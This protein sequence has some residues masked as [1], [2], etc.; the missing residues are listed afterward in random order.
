MHNFIKQLMIKIL[1]SILTSVLIITGSFLA[2][3]QK[4]TVTVINATNNNGKVSFALFDENG[5]P[6]EDYG[7]SNNILTFGLSSYSDSKFT[8]AEED[9]TLEAKF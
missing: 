6:T 4:I 5:I 3:K 9:L 1:A 7:A 2:P 8:L